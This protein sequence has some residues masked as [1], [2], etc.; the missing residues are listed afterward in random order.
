MG[1]HE[2]AKPGITEKKTSHGTWTVTPQQLPGLAST[3]SSNLP[4]P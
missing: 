1:K 3:L 2:T 4:C